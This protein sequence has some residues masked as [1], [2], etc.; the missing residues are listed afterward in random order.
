MKEEILEEI[1]IRTLDY[2]KKSCES[3]NLSS[4]EGMAIISSMFL[5]ILKN[6]PKIKSEEVFLE[7]CKNLWRENNEVLIED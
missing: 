1:I 4:I 3:Y 6:H 7:F 5:T 2:I